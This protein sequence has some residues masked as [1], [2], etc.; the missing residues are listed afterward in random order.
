MQSRE[1]LERRR[2]RPQGGPEF[3]PFALTSDLT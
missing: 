3:V 2:E 1:Y